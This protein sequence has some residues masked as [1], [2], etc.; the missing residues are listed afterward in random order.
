MRIYRMWIKIVCEEGKQ[1]SPQGSNP[2]K[3]VVSV[4]DIMKGQGKTKGLLVTYIASDVYSL[5]GWS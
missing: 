2:L 4:C 1:Q 3:S 5:P